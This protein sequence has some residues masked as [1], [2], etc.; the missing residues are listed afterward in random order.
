MATSVMAVVWT[1]HVVV[2]HKKRMRI[3]NFGQFSIAFNS[4]IAEPGEEIMQ[5]KEARLLEKRKRGDFSGS[6]SFLLNC[7]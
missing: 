3:P 2:E 6:A 7:T 1:L 4:T 5:T